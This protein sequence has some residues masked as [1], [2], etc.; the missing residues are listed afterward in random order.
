[1]SACHVSHHVT[2]GAATTTTI[3]MAARGSGASL[4][5]L[6][7]VGT[8]LSGAATFRR[9]VR[10]TTGVGGIN[11]WLEKEQSWWAEV[12]VLSGLLLLGL[13]R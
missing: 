12:E 11:F 8:L 6:F 2:S 3:S 1:M 4:V 9:K 13:S 10:K 7:T 5:F